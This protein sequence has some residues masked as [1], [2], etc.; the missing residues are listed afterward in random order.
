MVGNIINL[1]L[2]SYIAITSGYVVRCLH[3]CD[4]PTRPCSKTNSLLSCA[5]AWR[6]IDEITSSTTQLLLVIIS[7]KCLDRGVGNDFG[8]MTITKIYRFNERFHVTSQCGVNLKRVAKM[9][10]FSMAQE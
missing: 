8:K 4:C 9:Y 3:R 10:A 5:L 2:G 6:Y 7:P 1:S